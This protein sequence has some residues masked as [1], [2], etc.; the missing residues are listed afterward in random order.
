MTVLDTTVMPA[1]PGEWDVGGSD[2]S[3]ETS[4]WSPPPGDA[5]N[6]GAVETDGPLPPLS[7]RLQLVR[8]AI[9]SV[10]ALSFALL[11][12]VVVLSH[13]QQASSQKRAFNDF[14]DSLAEGT[15]PRGPTDAAGQVLAIGEPVAYLEIPAIGLEQVVVEGTTSGALFLGP[16]HRRDTPL[17]GQVGVSI[18]YGR[19]AAYGAPFAHIA[20]LEPGDMIT[21]STGQ[22]TF[23]YVVLGV[24][25]TGDP[26]PPDLVAGGSRLTLATASGARFLPGPVLFVDADI[27]A[28]TAVVGEP[29]S[30]PT[31]ALPGEEAAMAGDTRTLGA[32]LLWL[33][34]LIVVSVGAVWS[35]NRW[36]RERTWMV[37]LPP[38]LFVALG[39]SGEVVRLLP[40]LM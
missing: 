5:A 35:W 34:A 13:F 39:A 29:R 27:V 18:L 4:E 2:G 8:A 28:G 15:A 38:V 25:R 20:N 26:R 1:A 36:G 9:V 21:A 19:R 14:R 3:F 12:Q 11:L 10:F 31:S 37:F 40:N 7:P 30:I 23:E 32:L 17:P 24:R 16:G 6:G 33:Q 22:G